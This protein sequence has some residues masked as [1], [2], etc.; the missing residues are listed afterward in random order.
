MA[1]ETKFARHQSYAPTPLR[2]FEEVLETSFLLE[3]IVQ[4]P[5]D[6]KEGRHENNHGNRLATQERPQYPI[7]NLATI[8]THHRQQVE[9]SQPVVDVGRVL[10]CVLERRFTKCSDGKRGNSRERKVRD[11]SRHGDQ[12][13]VHRTHA[14][15]GLIEFH[16][17]PPP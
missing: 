6:G 3:S 5:L 9:N 16:I 13:L 10:D 14:V 12:H 11:G 1:S 4:E 8:E 17:S 2:A 15:E 7:E